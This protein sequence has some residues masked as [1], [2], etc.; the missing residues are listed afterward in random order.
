MFENDDCSPHR[1][2]LCG[3]ALQAVKQKQAD[4]RKEKSRYL[5]IPRAVNQ[6][7]CE[8]KE[9]KSLIKNKD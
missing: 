9:L 8:W 1:I 5:T 6:I 7:I 4:Y 2:D 3:E